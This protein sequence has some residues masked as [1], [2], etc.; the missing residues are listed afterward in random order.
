MT[1]NKIIT[2][3]IVFILLGAIVNVALAWYC[4]IC[5]RLTVN[6]EK[7]LFWSSADAPAFRHD[8]YERPGHCSIV[9]LLVRRQDQID[10]ERVSQPMRS[11]W[12]SELDQKRYYAA[13]KGITRVA[14]HGWPSYA[15]WGGFR[16]FWTDDKPAE[17][18]DYF[19]SIPLEDFGGKPYPSWLDRRA[20]P[21]RPL[22]PGFAINTIFYAAVLWIVFAAPGVIKRLRR[23]RR[24]QCIH[25]G[26][27]LRGQSG[28]G[29]GAQRCP[30]CGKAIPG[31]NAV[32]GAAAPC[33]PCSDDERSTT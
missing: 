7:G 19:G 5:V 28:S 22:W 32:H 8:V 13:P 10:P 30:E 14:A 18:L 20:L 24:G 11:C 6:D 15:L 25:C 31:R 23:R 27:D 3:A 4:A 2:R 29:N 12:F 33:N 1:R 21:L 9:T 17:P 16:L 26:Y